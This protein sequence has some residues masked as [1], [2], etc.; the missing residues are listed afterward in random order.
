MKPWPSSD[1]IDQNPTIGSLACALVVVK[2]III[3]AAIATVTA[4]FHRPKILL[5]SM[6]RSP[7]R[8]GSHRPPRNCTAGR[9]RFARQYRAGRNLAM[10][11]ST[12]VPQTILM[13]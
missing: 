3:R 13:R 4:L 10:L 11:G 5:A 7:L 8:L 2:P 6:I 1:V 9:E 12:S